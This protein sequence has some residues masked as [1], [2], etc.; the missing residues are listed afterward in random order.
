MYIF[1]AYQNTNICPNV[2]HYCI[3]L[4][5]QMLKNMVTTG[6]ITKDTFKCLSIIMLFK[7]IRPRHKKKYI[8]LINIMQQILSKEHNLSLLKLLIHFIKRPIED[9]YL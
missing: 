4:F 6:E 2:K 9:Y 8:L 5:M 3:L 1:Q 7:I